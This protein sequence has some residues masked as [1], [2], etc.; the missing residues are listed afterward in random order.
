V[1]TRVL[2]DSS[3]WRADFK[4][5]LE[6]KANLEDVKQTLDHVAESMEEKLGRT[7]LGPLLSPYVKG[8][9]LAGE[10]EIR[11]TK[12]EVNRWLDTKAEESDLRFELQKMSEKIE[13]LT[14]ELQS[15]QSSSA[16][17]VDITSLKEKVERKLDGDVFKD[18]I[19][20]CVTY[21]EFQEVLAKKADIEEVEELLDQKVDAQDL[22]QIIAVIEKKAESDIVDELVELVKY[23]AE[24]K[25]VEMISV[26]L[27]KKAD[28]RSCEDTS[29][30][31]TVL[32]KEVESL[33]QE[34]DQTFTEIRSLMEKNRQDL[35]ICTKEIN[36]RATKVEVVDIKNLL[37]KRV[38]TSFFLEELSK[39]KD[40]VSKENKNSKS[41]A[42]KVH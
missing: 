3:E 33:F 22:N 39:V 20:N 31:M 7:D 37:S 26:A 5:E 1:E 19:K 15:L 36:K 2:C 29:E 11:P 30:Q 14:N 8:D 24:A 38:E 42:E 9:E 13:R 25:D 32:R 21:D 6:A 12:T 35:E 23:K 4:R 40:E 18:S 28:K 16:S 27:N 17:I 41:E 10:L 34:F